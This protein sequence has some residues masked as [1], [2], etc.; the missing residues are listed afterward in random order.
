MCKHVDFWCPHTADASGNVR[1]LYSYTS[2]LLHL[3]KQLRKGKFVYFWLDALSLL[4]HTAHIKL[5]LF[6]LWPNNDYYSS[7]SFSDESL[8]MLIQQP[9]SVWVLTH[10]TVLSSWAL[11]QGIGGRLPN[12]LGKVKLRLWSAFKLLQSRSV[13]QCFHTT[14]QQPTLEHHGCGVSSNR[15][16]CWTQL[17]SASS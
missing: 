13:K 6:L 1:N 7:W 4:T 15:S 17:C 12:W 16:S 3:G 11:Q 2:I 9:Q 8:R 10:V 14:F 5:C